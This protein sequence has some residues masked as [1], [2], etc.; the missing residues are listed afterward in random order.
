MRLID[1]WKGADFIAQHIDGEI[2]LKVQLK[3]RFTLD[4]KYIGKSIYIAFPEGE[5]WYLYPHDEALDRI[6]ELS[7]LKNSSAWGRSGLRHYPKIPSR[8]KEI[9]S[10]YRIFPYKQNI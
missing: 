9:L 10:D 1:D 3:A 6:S 2:Y 7:G 4:K 8:F 5:E